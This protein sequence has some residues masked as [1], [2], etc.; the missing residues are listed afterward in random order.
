MPEVPG[1]L[2]GASPS[3]SPCVKFILAMWCSVMSVKWNGH[4]SP[5]CDDNGV[6]LM[7]FIVNEKLVAK[8]TIKWKAKIDGGVPETW[9]Q[10]HAAS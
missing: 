4:Q 1:N 7:Q 9:E 5:F 10:E 8:A 3:C 2:L 6:Q